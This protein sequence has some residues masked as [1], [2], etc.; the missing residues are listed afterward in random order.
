MATLLAITATTV[1]M[2]LVVARL[3][4][5]VIAGEPLAHQA[6]LVAVVVGLQAARSLLARQRR[7]LA[8]RVANEVRASVRARLARALVA[9]GPSRLSACRTGEVTS[10]VVDGIESLDPW[11]HLSGSGWRRSPAVA[12]RR[13]PAERSSGPW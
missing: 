11:V 9:T 8:A 12:S 3:L 7:V 6:P 5:A 4:A 13:F 10:V 1:S 2:G